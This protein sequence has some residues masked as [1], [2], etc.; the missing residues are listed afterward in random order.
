M[1]IEI[2]LMKSFS[3]ST[4]PQNSLLNKSWKKTVIAGVKRRVFQRRREGGLFKH[5]N[6]KMDCCC[7]MFI[8]LI[9]CPSLEIISSWSWLALLLW[10]RFQCGWIQI[11]RSLSAQW[12]RRYP[13]STFSSSSSPPKIRKVP[14]HFNSIFIHPIWD[15]RWVISRKQ[16]IRRLHTSTNCLSHN[17]MLS[18]I[19]C[20]NHLIA[21]PLHQRWCLEGRFGRQGANFKACQNNPLN[22][23]HLL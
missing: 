8:Q 2:F 1:K 23:F 16:Q 15:H 4:F 12:Q 17:F 19:S 14:P 18:W 7:I 20:S 6:L 22:T 11:K 21:H 13:E 10:L 9:Y 5:L 3:K